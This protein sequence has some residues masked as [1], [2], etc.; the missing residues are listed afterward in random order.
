M[1]N[2]I[3]IAMS[4]II[5]GS[6]L[7][8]SEAGS[9]LLPQEKWVARYNGPDN[10][11]DSAN[12]VA[13]DNLGNVYVT[14]WSQGSGGV[15][16]MDYATVKYN[17]NGNQLWAKRYN[18][19]ANG[20]DDAK[21][22]AVDGLGNVYVT[23]SSLGS[24]TNLDYSTIKYGPKGKQLWAIRYNGPA[25]G[26]D[27]ARAIAVDGSGNVYVTGERGGTSPNRSD[28][29]TI[30]YNTNGKQLWVRRYNG[31]ADLDFDSAW[32]IAVDDSGNVYVS[33]AS[34][35]WGTYYDYVTI[36]YSTKGK[37]LWEKRYVAQ[38]GFPDKVSLAVDGSGNVYVTGESVGSIGFRDYATIKYST[39]GEELWVK[40][41]NGPANGNDK[42]RAIAVDG[43]G[44]VYI[45]GFSKG[46][47]GTGS[48]YATVKYSPNGEQLWAILY[49]GP[50]W[51]D[52]VAEA[53]AVDGSG[54]VYITG[55]SMSYGSDYATIKYSTNGEQVWV[56]RYVGPYGQGSWAKAIVVDNNGNVYVTGE[57]AGLG[58]GCDY[59]TIKY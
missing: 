9:V 1:K 28:Y 43:S 41:Y 50:L 37:P 2:N 55:R 26:N 49:N 24:G 23:G 4:S 3:W 42:A 13:V 56:K 18:G 47:V 27:K 39:N 20:V 36:K 44:N 25:N 38:A 54:N 48:D 46:L 8:P 40:R 52:D 34:Y 33:G 57:S 12:A 17:I 5:V 58:T 53:I 6:L 22:I 19:P 21:A 10:G 35:S 32:S 11:L 16:N 59:A 14:G 31:P 45:T 30:K 15:D 7:I 29:A 51:G